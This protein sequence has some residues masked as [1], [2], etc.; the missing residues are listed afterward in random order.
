MATHGIEDVMNL[1]FHSRNKR[2][3]LKLEMSAASSTTSRRQTTIKQSTI[4]ENIKEKKTDF[5]QRMATQYHAAGR[6]LITF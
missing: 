2:V 6:N 1:H 4:P 3:A 5:Q